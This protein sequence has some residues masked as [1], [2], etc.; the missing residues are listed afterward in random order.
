MSSKYVNKFSSLSDIQNL[1]GDAGF[2][3]Y[4]GGIFYNADGTVRSIGGVPI[5]KVFYVN[6][7]TGADT[8]DGRS[9]SSAFK[10]LATAYAAMT[11]G[12]ND[13]CVIIGSGNTTNTVR[14]DA[15]F[16]WAKDAC[17]LVGVCAPS[18]FS[19]RAR[20]APT[21]S[22][23]AFTPFFT[24]SGNGCHFAN[25]QFWHGFD[26]GAAAQ[27]NLV[28]SG[29]RNVFY[30]VHV[31][32]LG[33]TDSAADADSRDLK[34]G[35]SGA[36]ENVFED[37]VIGIDTIARGAANAHVEF[38]GGAVRNIFLRCVFASQASAGTPL[39][40]IGSA[41]SCID[42]FNYF[43]D[44]IWTNF[45]TTRTAVATLPA[46]AGGTLVFVNPALFNVTGFGSDATTR[47]QALVMGPSGTAATTGI[48][49]APTA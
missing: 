14:V 42:R 4:N 25:L 33:D 12:A 8:N 13:V 21:G 16:T 19:P 34:L 22:T 26:T 2:G 39:S 15:A 5:G 38:T 32:G 31:A 23:T 10:T 30:R 36:G 47:G 3:A 40:V 17:H 20:I 7:A 9:P 29:S 41:A 48:S 35:G 37:C 44:C 46:S 43:I 45:G 18:F 6:Y 11:S 24:I 1:P 49:L 27:I 28:V